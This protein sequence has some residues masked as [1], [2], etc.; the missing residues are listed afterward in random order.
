M[1]CVLV[2]AHKRKQAPLPGGNGTC[3]GFRYRVRE[4]R[5]S[6]GK[7]ALVVRGGKERDGRNS[8]DVQD[9]GAGDLDRRRN[10]LF[11][12]GV[13]CVSGVWLDEVV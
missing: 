10:P 7:P 5:G 13:Q 11:E 2:S 8:A 4:E 9:S 12:L 3:L 6:V 1:R